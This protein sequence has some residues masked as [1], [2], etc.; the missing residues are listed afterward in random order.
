MILIL[1]KGTDTFTVYNEHFKG[2]FTWSIVDF[3]GFIPDPQTL[4]T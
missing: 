1:I 3:N 4:N 2:R